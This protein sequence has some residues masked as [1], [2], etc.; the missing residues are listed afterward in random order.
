MILDNS[1]LI[2]TFGAAIAIAAGVMAKNSD[3]QM[4]HRPLLKNFGMAS[5]VL[6]WVLMA[7]SL[8][9][10]KPNKI[11]YWAPC[12]AI[13]GSVLQ[14]KKAK[15]EDKKPDKIY[16]ITFAGSW[17]M[18]GYLLS[19]NLDMKIFGFLPPALVLSSMMFILPWQRTNCIVDGPG[20]PMFT[21]GLAILATINSM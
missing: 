10:G 11:L 12:M 5:F 14:M 6:G 8:S 15:S 3:E 9:M 2:P 13:L 19:M 16:P 20:L 1:K 17:L 7:F 4:E 18:L 21:T